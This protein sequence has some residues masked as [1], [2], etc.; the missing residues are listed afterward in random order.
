MNVCAMVRSVSLWLVVVRRRYAV[1]TGIVEAKCW[2]KN[3]WTRHG[4]YSGRPKQWRTDTLRV[5]LRRLL[6][7]MSGE[8]RKPHT[9]MRLRHWLGQLLANVS[10]RWSNGSR[11][12]PGGVAW[13]GVGLRWSALPPCFSPPILTG[14]HSTSL[15]VRAPV[16]SR[17]P[18][19]LCRDM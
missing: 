15:C 1:R 7:T 12:L 10:A 3:I 8:P 17:L 2:A 11:N 5:S 4:L 6:R 9:L 18:A 19:R 13:G 16:R 14:D